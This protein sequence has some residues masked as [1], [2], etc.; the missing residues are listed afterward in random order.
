MMMHNSDGNE[1]L[2]NE[3]SNINKHMSLKLNKSISNSES[4]SLSS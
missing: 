3:K 2:T 1:C 4:G